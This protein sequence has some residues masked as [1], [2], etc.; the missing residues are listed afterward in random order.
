MQLIVHFLGIST[1]CFSQKFSFIYVTQRKV[2]LENQIVRFKKEGN[3]Y[4][5]ELVENW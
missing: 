4:T 1:F 3:K 2:Y 5:D